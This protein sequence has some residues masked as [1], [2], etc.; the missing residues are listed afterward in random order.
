MRFAT[1]RAG[2]TNFSTAIKIIF[3]NPKGVILDFRK[4]KRS[5]K[6]EMM[7]IICDKNI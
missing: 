7:Q 1:F 5:L 6:V 3:P 2:A 4:Y